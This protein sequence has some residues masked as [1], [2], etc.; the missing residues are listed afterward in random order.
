MKIKD[1]KKTA[2]FSRCNRYRYRLERAWDKRISRQSTV[3]FVG[4]NPSTADANKDDPTIRKC[5]A[6]A[7][8]WQYKKLIMV[9]LFAWRAT[10]PIDLLAADEPIGKL[11]NRHLDEAIAQS[12]LVLACWGEHGTLLNRS[13]EFRQQ[14]ARR[15]YCLK[16]NASG[17]PTHPLYLPATLRPVKLTKI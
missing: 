4:L 6:Y 16:T 15:L 10:D 9:N 2:A 3:A 7:Q 12:A 1:T 17:E 14:Y 8:R 13:A 5:T 11:N